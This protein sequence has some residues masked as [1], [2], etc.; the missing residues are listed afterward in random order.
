MPAVTFLYEEIPLCGR[1]SVTFMN[2]AAVWRRIG[3]PVQNSTGPHTS[4]QIGTYIYACIT[5]P[6]A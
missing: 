1:R 6:I 2:D 4:L 5:H 3:N